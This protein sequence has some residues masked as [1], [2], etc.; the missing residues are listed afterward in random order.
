MQAHQKAFIELARRYEVLKFGEFTLKSGR[1]SPY[2]F[3]AGAFASGEVTL[4]LGEAVTCIIVNDDQAPSLTVVKQVVNDD[5]GGATVGEFGISTSAGALVFGDGNT[6]GDI[7]TYTAELTGLNAGVSYS[8][9]ELDVF[10][11]SEGT[12][13]CMPNPGG[14][15]FGSTSRD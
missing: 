13:N 12:W 5:G 3:N 14:G 7:T 15:A 8:L 11:Y 1:T 10:G 2:F 9:A 4:G 6:V